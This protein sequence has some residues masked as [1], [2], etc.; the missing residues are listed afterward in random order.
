[1]Y[2]L[3]LELQLRSKR[4]KLRSK[5]LEHQLRSKRSKLRSKFRTSIREITFKNIE[6][7]F[8]NIELTFKNIVIYIKMFLNFNYVL[9]VLNYVLNLRSKSTFCFV[10]LTVIVGSL[11]KEYTWSVS[12]CLNYLSA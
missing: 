2:V 4:S 10:G 8:K 6:L 7:T 9:Y 12:T 5:I 1:M 11:I 3:N